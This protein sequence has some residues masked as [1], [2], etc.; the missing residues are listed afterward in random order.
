LIKTVVATAGQSV[1]IGSHVRV[2]GVLVA[3]SA[4]ANTDGKG[5]P[6]SPFGGGTVPANTVFLHASFVGSYD[7]PTFGPL[8]VSGILGL[9]QEVFT[10]AP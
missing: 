4:I 5:R 10:Y 3:S 1:E 6:L 7:S 8:P 2:D 9:A